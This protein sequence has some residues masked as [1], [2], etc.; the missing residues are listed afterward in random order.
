MTTVSELGRAFNVSH[1]YVSKLVKRGMPLT[2]VQAAQSWRDTYARQ[3]PPTDPKQLQILHVDED[4][5]KDNGNAKR[6]RRASVLL[7][8]CLNRLL[9]SED[10]LEF[11][12]ACSRQ[13]ERAAHI[14]FQQ[15]LKERRESKIIA[16]FRN[17]NAALD[18]RLKIEQWYR[19]EADY[20]HQLIPMEEVRLL[21]CKG[22]NVI[23]SRL[24]AFPEKVGP[25]CNPEAPAH[26]M[27]VLRDEC[28]N[29]IA[30]IKKSWPEHFL[31][32]WFGLPFPDGDIKRPAV[33]TFYQ[34][35]PAV[36]TLAM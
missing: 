28:T 8:K 24:V 6:R 2:S 34:R 19:N 27:A 30:D 5:A 36:A 22:L 23:I 35:D 18:A 17:Y 4:V 11:P 31:M 25:T 7:Q 10:S 32:T 14:L 13:I 9:P 21:M 3:R 29:V 15:A 26:A 20:R 1:Q 12:L 16:A 33:P